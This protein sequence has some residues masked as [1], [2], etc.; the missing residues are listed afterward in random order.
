MDNL[1]TNVSIEKDDL[2]KAEALF[3]AEREHLGI[4]SEEA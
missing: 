2:K 4:M 3:L 1:N